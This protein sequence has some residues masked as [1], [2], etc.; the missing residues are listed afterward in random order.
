MYLGYEPNVLG[1]PPPSRL[2]ACNS[3]PLASVSLGYTVAW[4][5]SHRSSLLLAVGA[6]RY[7]HVGQVLLFQAPK[8]GGNWS[9]IQKIEGTQVRVTGRASARAA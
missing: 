6:P 7:Q 8:A 5:P 4:M 3:K 2:C 9:Q 1:S